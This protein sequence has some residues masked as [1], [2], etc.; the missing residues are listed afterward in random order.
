[1]MDSVRLAMLIHFGAP[2]KLPKGNRDPRENQWDPRNDQSSLICLIDARA[3]IEQH[4]YCA[5]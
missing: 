1:M 3:R 2:A 5:T 4:G